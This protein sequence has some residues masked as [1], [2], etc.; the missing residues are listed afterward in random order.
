[1]LYSYAVALTGSIATGKSSAA[2]IFRDLGYE[3]IDADEVAHRVLDS[4]SEKIVHLFGESYVHCGAVDRKKLGALVFGDNQKRKA[5]ENLLH[6]LIREDIEKIALALDDKKLTYLVDVPLFYET[7]RYDIDD[8]IVVY[9]PEKIQIQRLMARDSLSY[10]EARQRIS[11][12][13]S[14]EEKKDRATYLLDNSGSKKELLQSCLR[15][16]KILKER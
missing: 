16:N 7:G 9:A 1:M 8:V 4:Q 10:S 2:D 14:I 5:L 15:V 11:A 6:P 12:Q 13:I 3:V